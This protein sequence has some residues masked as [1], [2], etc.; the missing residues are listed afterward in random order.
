VKTADNWSVKMIGIT[1]VEPP[2]TPVSSCSI[3][4]TQA[5]RSIRRTGDIENIV[6][7]V[8]RSAK[9]GMHDTSAVKT[10]PPVVVCEPMDKFAMINRPASD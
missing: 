6:V 10:L 1:A 5:G 3:I 8:R 4:R 9:Q 7:N 2:D